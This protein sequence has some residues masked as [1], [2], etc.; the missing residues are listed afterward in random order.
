MYDGPCVLLHLHLSIIPCSTH[1]PMAFHSAEGVVSC[2]L[3]SHFKFS[4]KGTPSAMLSQRGNQSKS[5]GRGSQNMGCAEGRTDL[6]SP[7]ADCTAASIASKNVDSMLFSRRSRRPDVWF[8]LP[9]RKDGL[10]LSLN[11]PHLVRLPH[12][13]RGQLN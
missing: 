10:R 13:C 11:M 4:A 3:P 9:A 6:K 8:S 12:I 1:T 5:R 2:N 7:P